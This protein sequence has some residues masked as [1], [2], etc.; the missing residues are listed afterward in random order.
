MS[1]TADEKIIKTQQGW[2]KSWCV[3]VKEERRMRV[4][5]QRE[6]RKIFGFK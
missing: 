1:V 6:L 5:K 2:N 3:T 4:L